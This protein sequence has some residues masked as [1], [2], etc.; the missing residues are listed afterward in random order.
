MG[1]K[2]YFLHPQN[3]DFLENKLQTLA[4]EGEVIDNLDIELKKVKF[5]D[6]LD[7]NTTLILVIFI[8]FI[9]PPIIG[10]VLALIYGIGFGR[11]FLLTLNLWFLI[12]GLGF[13]LVVFL[14]SFL[15]LRPFFEMGYEFLS[16][17]IA[18][19]SSRRAYKYMLKKRMITKGR[20]ASIELQNDKQVISYVFIPEYG[21]ETRYSQRHSQY[22]TENKHQIVVGNFV[23][24]LYTP[25]LSIPL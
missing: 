2:I 17:I 18:N 23:H 9:T 19:T 14:M 3:Q 15:I 1:E 4:N 16:Y 20:V 7:G 21:F 6:L 22:V 25:H 8:I 10:L 24:V 11:E 13:L 5:N 12:F